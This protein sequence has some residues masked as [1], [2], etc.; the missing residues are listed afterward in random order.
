MDYYLCSNCERYLSPNSKTKSA[1]KKEE[2]E[3]EYPA[4]CLVCLGVWDD[5]DSSSFGTRLA[6]ALQEALQPY[7]THHSDRNYFCR[8]AVVPV[9]ALPGHMIR[10]YQAIVV[11]QGQSNKSKP[12]FGWAQQ[13]KAH[14]KQVLDKT[15]DEME[16][17]WHTEAS[18]T[19]NDSNGSK[20]TNDQE[21]LG[22]LGV[23]VIVTAAAD[24]SRHGD[25]SSSS[26]SR[27]PR[28]KRRKI[29]GPSQGGDARRNLELR[30]GKEQGTAVWSV[31]QA[32]DDENK[33][34]MDDATCLAFLQPLTR[35]EQPAYNIHVAVWR[36]PFYVRGEYTKIRRDVSQTPFYVQ[37][38]SQERK[39]LGISSVE[40]EILPVL[41]K[42]C[43]GISVQNNDPTTSG[44]GSGSNTV[45]G[46]AKFHASGREDMDVRMLL[47]PPPATGESS[48]SNNITGRPFVCQVTDAYKIPSNADLERVVLEINHLQAGDAILADSKQSF[49][50]NPN[51]VGV[52]PG[53]KHVPSSSFKNLQADTEDKVKHYGCL[54]WSRDVLP[55]TDAA[56]REKLGTFPVALEQR[57]PIRVLHRR[58][59]MIRNRNVLSCSVQRIDEHY[60]RLHISTDAGTYVKEFVHGDLG[61]TKP[62][63][64][65]ILGCKADILELDCEG[66]EQG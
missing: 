4:T 20:E 26:S 59:N 10:R 65:S 53:L 46:M 23:H 48:K 58:S 64:G 19:T 38:D 52:A 49:G 47:P 30:I 60:F 8:H 11:R 28:S 22:H 51:G 32:L 16:R 37:D 61:R 34:K 50:K 24:L 33:T 66:I 17:K 27:Q 35:R 45:F 15:L 12:A 29:D 13:I 21:E 31:N 2:S 1:K 14:T 54:C 63:I 56:L 3:T 41:V 44:G 6:A 40:E 55:D 7:A 36:R 57:T 25:K 9:V 39:R 62:S 42:H 43:G 18:S 5:N